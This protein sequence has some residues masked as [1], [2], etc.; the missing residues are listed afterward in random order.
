MGR[1]VAGQER[2]LQTL[3]GAG[4]RPYCTLAAVSEAVL[5]PGGCGGEI[6][7]IFSFRRILFSIMLEV[8]EESVNDFGGVRL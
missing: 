5:A 7:D 2:P 3:P 6:N 4:Q 1:Q 8:F